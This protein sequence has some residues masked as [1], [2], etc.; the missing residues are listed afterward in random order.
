MVE[1][2][3]EAFREEYDELDDYPSKVRLCRRPTVS[4]DVDFVCLELL[5][6]AGIRAFRAADFTV[7]VLYQFTEAERSDAAP[8]LERITRNLSC[9]AAMPAE[10]ADDSPSE[11]PDDE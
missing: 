2:A 11:E 9:L 7:L 4:R 8:I 5:N 3:V 1:A 10:E 6:S